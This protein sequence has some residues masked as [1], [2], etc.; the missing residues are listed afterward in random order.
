M[1]SIVCEARRVRACVRS[2]LLRGTIVNSTNP[3]QHIM[4]SKLSIEQYTAPLVTALITHKC[5]C[6]LIHTR[7]LPFYNNLF[8]FMILEILPLELSPTLPHY[9]FIQ[10]LTQYILHNSFN[11]S[12]SI[13]KICCSFAPLKTLLFTSIPLQSV[14][15]ISQHLEQNVY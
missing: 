1:F 14:H 3:T 9:S 15:P 5:P 7:F 13:R 2:N 10:Q 4:A 11:E 12:K 8:D 6:L